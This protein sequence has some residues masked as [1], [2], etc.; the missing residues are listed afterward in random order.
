[1]DESL[2]QGDG[3]QAILD[4]SADADEAHAVR[5]ERAQVASGWIIWHPDR[6]KAIVT[7]EV[8][9]VQGVTAI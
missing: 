7:Q 8:E 6:G 4:H 3:V 1:M 9:D 2:L 5:E